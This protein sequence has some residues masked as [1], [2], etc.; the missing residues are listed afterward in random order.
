MGEKEWKGD[1]AFSI[2]MNNY[3]DEIYRKVFPVAHITRL[4][5][6]DTPHILDKKFHIDVLIYLKNG[7]LITAQEKARRLEYL[8]FQDFTLEYYSNEFGKPGEYSK[9]CT[10]IYFY[11][12]GSPENGFSCVYIFKPIDVKMAILNSELIGEL[13]QNQYHSSA[14]FYAYP[15]KDFKDDWFIYKYKAVDELAD[16]A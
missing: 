5:R 16:K 2:A 9:L 13:K 4:T 10:D 6:E 12:Y 14:N 1:I 8:N 3:I 7:I 11:G 15:F